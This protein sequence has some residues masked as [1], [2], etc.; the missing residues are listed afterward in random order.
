MSQEESFDDPNEATLTLY[1]EVVGSLVMV[2]A[3]PAP[4]GQRAIAW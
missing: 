1:H 2:L 4:S 3:A